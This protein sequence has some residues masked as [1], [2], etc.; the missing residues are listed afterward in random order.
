MPIYRKETRLFDP[1]ASGRRASHVNWQLASTND[2]L[3]CIRWHTIVKATLLLRPASSILVQVTFEMHFHRLKCT[4]TYLRQLFPRRQSFQV[5]QTWPPSQGSTAI[6][7]KRNDLQLCELKPFPEVAEWYTMP[8]PHSI[9]VHSP[10]VLFAESRKTVWHGRGD[11]AVGTQWEVKR[12]NTWGRKCR[13]Y[14][15]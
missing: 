2:L 4:S 13:G 7:Q 1:I 5:R 3:S 10:V 15:G 14:E 9:T 11:Q 12:T 6:L 8:R